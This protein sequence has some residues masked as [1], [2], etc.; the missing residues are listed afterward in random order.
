[1]K[2][3]K[4]VGLDYDEIISSVRTV[5]GNTG[6][7]TVTRGKPAKTRKYTIVPVCVEGAQG[8]CR[9][10]EKVFSQNSRELSMYDFIRQHSR[11]IPEIYRL[12]LEKRTVLMEDMN[13]DYFPGFN[14]NENNEYG[15]TF[16]KNHKTVLNAV[17]KFHG[18][19][20][21]NYDAFG[22]IGLDWR[23]ESKENLV[24]HIEGMG[25]DFKK[26][27]NSEKAGRIPQKSGTFEN[28]IKPEKLEHFN[29]ALEMLKTEYVKLIDGRFNKGKNITVI[30]GDLHPGN[31]YMSKSGSAIK[32]IDMEAVRI[33]LCTE[34][35]AMFL[36]LHVEPDLKT[37]KPLLV[38]YHNS[39]CENAKDY[40]FD[41]FI[42]DYK[43][44]VME[45]MFFPIRLINR[46]IFD[47]NMRD[48]AIKAFETLVLGSM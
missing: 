48:R 10:I 13:A 3:A 28:N 4:P 41:E 24:A 47:F 46:G 43:I 36:A 39:L 34:D 32:Y 42:A 18:A 21:E 26:Y 25:K 33:G 15:D 11:I 45:N 5:K 1:M 35:L 30:H 12:D 7:L 9:L 17:A 37:V 20:W 22:R 23:L 6:E 44:S 19:F 16:R 29:T 38:H 14:F 8:E 2:T 40:S 27:K 31:I